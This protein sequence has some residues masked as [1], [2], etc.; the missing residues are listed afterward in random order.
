[1]VRAHHMSLMGNVVRGELH[2]LPV[3]ELDVLAVPRGRPWMGPADAEW[4]A[5]LL[6]LRVAREGRGYLGP[7]QI[8]TDAQ[9]SLHRWS[10]GGAAAVPWEQPRPGWRRG[11][12]VTWVGREPIAEADHALR[13]WMRFLVPSVLGGQMKDLEDALSLRGSVDLREPFRIRLS[14]QGGEVAAWVEATDLPG[15]ARVYC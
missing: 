15:G 13:F 2:G 8:L 7:L 14:L 1:M 11:A 10:Q 4:R 5:L 12:F 9:S 3:L 6:A